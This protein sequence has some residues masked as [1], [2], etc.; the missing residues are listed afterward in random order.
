MLLPYISASALI[1]GDVII[2]LTLTL[3]LYVVFERDNAKGDT[4]ED[5]LVLIDSNHNNDDEGARERFV[6]VRLQNDLELCNNN[7]GTVDGRLF[8]GDDKTVANFG[9]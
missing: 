7:N 5:V 9:I 2:H 3:L 1:T 4:I 6:F 8:E